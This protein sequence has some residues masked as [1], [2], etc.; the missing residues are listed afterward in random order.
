MALIKCPECSAEVS[1]EARQCVQCGAQLRQ[2]KGSVFGWLFHEP[3]ATRSE[4]ERT[5]E[6][7]TDG[8]EG[9]VEG[10][11][12]VQR[13]ALTETTPEHTRTYQANYRAGLVGVLAGESAGKALRRTI[14]QINADGRRVAFMVK[15]RWSIW[16]WLGA[17]LL[18]LLTVGLV[19]RA[20]GYLVIAELYDVPD[21][22]DVEADDMGGASDAGSMR[23]SR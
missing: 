17:L 11:R 23:E 1:S 9:T 16:Q 15:N 19:G 8:G 3:A 22:A 18:F 6:M 12:R 7:A 13:K 20:P 14:E 21:A 10:G 5:R 4:A 2:P